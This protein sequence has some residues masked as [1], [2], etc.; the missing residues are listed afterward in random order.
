MKVVLMTAALAVALVSGR[1]LD[2]PEEG[3]KQRPVKGVA[4][5]ERVGQARALQVPPPVQMLGGFKPSSGVVGAIHPL[6]STETTNNTL[7]SKYPDFYYKGYYDNKRAGV[8]AEA[9]VEDDNISTSS[10][11]VV[12]YSYLAAPQDTSPASSDR[13]VVYGSGSAAKPPTRGLTLVAS[14]TL[15]KPTKTSSVL[16]T[17]QTNTL[18][19]GYSAPSTVVVHSDPHRLEITSRSSQAPASPTP[20]RPTRTVFSANPGHFTIKESTFQA[21]PGAPAF[22]VPV[23]VPTSQAL[24]QH[25]GKDT[26]SQASSEVTYHASTYSTY[27]HYQEPSTKKPAYQKMMEPFRKMGERFYEMASPVLEPVMSAGYRLSERL[28]LSQR[29]NSLSDTLKLDSMNKYLGRTAEDDSLPVVAGAAAVTAFGLLGLAIAA[30]NNITFPGKR[31]IDS[32]SLE[33]LDQLVEEAPLGEPTL[34]HRFQ[35]YAPWVGSRCSRRIICHLM[36][37][38]SD[39]LLYS[40]EKRLDTFL[41][42]LNRGSD[43][44]PSLMHVADDVMRAAH[45]KQC[46]VFACGGDNTGSSQVSRGD[47]GPQ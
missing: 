34:L 33:F 23:P 41:G 15:S 27:D 25:P 40:L 47:S 11:Q 18:P 8:V 31:S 14:P 43:E 36:T 1:S 24:L 20:P 13:N 42:M 45:R 29:M 7:P 6:S 32:P 35:E 28:Q 3:T 16:S 10:E 26:A 5:V 37:Y 4:T 46:D 19:V 30:A 44:E 17:S 12:S 38:A 22:T 21:H 2:T 9:S 39:D